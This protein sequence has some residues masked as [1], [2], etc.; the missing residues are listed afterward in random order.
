M[1]HSEGMA[2]NSV[3]ILPSL[4]TASRALGEL[5]LADEDQ[6]ITDGVFQLL[7]EFSLTPYR[8]L[9]GGTASMPGTIHKLLVSPLTYRGRKIYH[10]ERRGQNVLGVAQ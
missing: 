1:G 5:V 2:V 4:S 6:S 9:K 7:S 10:E 3:C 8:L